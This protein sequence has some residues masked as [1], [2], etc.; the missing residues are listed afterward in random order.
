MSLLTRRY[1][2]QI[3]RV[4]LTNEKFFESRYRWITKEKNGRIYGRAPKMGVSI[5]DLVKKREK[6]YWGEKILPKNVKVFPLKYNHP[7]T[8]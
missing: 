6:D 7:S 4:Q 5:K 3:R 1:V 8:R 2:G